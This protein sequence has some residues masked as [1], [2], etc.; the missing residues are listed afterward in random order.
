MPPPRSGGSGGLPTTLVAALCLLAFF[1]GRFLSL[2][3]FPAAAG[4]G[5]RLAEGPARPAADR[6]MLLEADARAAPALARQPALPRYASF[7]ELVEASGMLA[8]RPPLAPGASGHAFYTVQPMQ[9]LS[10]YPRAYLLPKFVDPGRCA[11]VVAA[12]S[13][14]L[15][16]SGLALKKGDTAEGTVNIRTSQGA[17]LGRGDAPALAWIEDKIGAW[18]WCG[19]LRFAVIR[20]VISASLI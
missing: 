2:P 17:F 14:L 11:E 5:P 13:A 18:R 8:D 19:R 16:P 9:L 4:R 6:K 12:A 20:V 7:E 10:W 15:A 1:A 3:G